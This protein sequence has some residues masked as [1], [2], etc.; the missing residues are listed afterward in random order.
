[1]LKE[2]LKYIRLSAAAGALI[3]F[4]FVSFDEAGLIGHQVAASAVCINCA[5]RIME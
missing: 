2:L 3:I 1:M 5:Q 4:F